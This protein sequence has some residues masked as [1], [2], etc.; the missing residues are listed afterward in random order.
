[1]GEGVLPD[2]IES[3]NWSSMFVKNLLPVTLGNILGGAGFTG[4][5]YW[6]VYLRRDKK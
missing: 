2:L 4:L 1:M 6:F 5:I 3:L